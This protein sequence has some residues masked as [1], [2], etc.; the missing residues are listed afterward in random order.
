MRRLSPAVTWSISIFLALLFAAVG[1]SKIWGASATSWSAR[2]SNWGLPAG[3]RYV[4]GVVEMAGGLA[5]FLPRTRKLAAASLV[6]T[7]AGALAVH[8][9]HGELLRVIPPL[10]LGF[11]SFLLF[12]SA[13][14]AE[15]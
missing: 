4:I 10:I 5:L 8:L 7:M 2:L 3:S 1:A 13:P 14:S 6:V 9:I 11:L 15:H 12:Y